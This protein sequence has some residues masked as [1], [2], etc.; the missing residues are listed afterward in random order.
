MNIKSFI[1]R[2]LFIGQMECKYIHDNYLRKTVATMK[3]LD[4]AQI[5]GDNV[6]YTMLEQFVH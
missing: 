5:L 4:C 3:K 2:K 6:P 1:L